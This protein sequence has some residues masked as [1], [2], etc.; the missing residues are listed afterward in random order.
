MGDKKKR[1]DTPDPAGQGLF[2]RVRFLN[3]LLLSFVLLANA[4]WVNAQEQPERRGSRVID[5]TTKQVYGPNTSRYYY[6]RDVFYNR[7]VLHPIDTFIRNYHR[8]SS[9]VQY[10]N[11]LVMEFSI[12]LKGLIA[13]G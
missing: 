13:N 10:N 6:E 7:Q 2:L 11:N 12:K 5:D 8:N 3:G 4:A 1:G 9:Y